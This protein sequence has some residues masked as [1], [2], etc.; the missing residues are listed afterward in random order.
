MKFSYA[1]SP[2]GPY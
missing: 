2:T 1:K